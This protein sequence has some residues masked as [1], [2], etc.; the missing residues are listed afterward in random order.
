MMTSSSWSQSKCKTE[1]VRA[2]QRT[3]N[4]SL[5]FVL[6]KYTSHSHTNYLREKLRDVHWRAYGS[7][8]ERILSCVRC[9]QRGVKWASDHNR[10]R[11]AQWELCLMRFAAIACR[12]GAGAA[13]H[14]R[15]MLQSLHTH[16]HTQS[17]TETHRI[18]SQWIL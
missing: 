15:K 12:L 18:C 2:D 7:L 16:S 11:R 13:Q 17:K 4:I 8:C 3:N 10:T 9:E 6:N 14:G 5:V 1:R